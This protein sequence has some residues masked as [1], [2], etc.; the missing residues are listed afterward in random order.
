MTD[1]DSVIPRVKRRAFLVAGVA[2]LGA[3]LFGVRRGA[4]LTICAAVVISSFLA[5]EK[6][7]ERLDPGRARPGLR[8]LVSLLL[9]TVASFVLLGVVLWRWKGF[10][11]VAGAFGLS[12][13]VLA[14]I[15]ELWTRR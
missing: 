12:V 11:P 13:V 6:V 2:I 3:F 8:T 15:P 14:I 5:L 7:L 1:A 10:D 9:V 4:S